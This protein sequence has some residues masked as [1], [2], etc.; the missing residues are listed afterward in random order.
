MRTSFYNIYIDNINTHELIN[1]LEQSLFTQEELQTIF[2][3]NAHCFNIAQR[4]PEYIA[5]LHKGTYSLNDGIGMKLASFL[6]RIKL[7]ENMN[8]TDLIPKILQ[9]CSKLPV[10]VYLLGG[11]PG[12]AAQARIKMSNRIPGLNIVGEHDGYFSK[13]ENDSV[14]RDIVSKRTDV[15]ILGMGVP[16]QEIWIINNKDSLKNVK[17]AIAGGAILDFEAGVVKRAPKWI[18]TLYLEWFF[19]F[20]QEPRRL[21]IRYFYGNILFFIN[22]IKT[23]NAE[24][25]KN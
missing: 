3:V 17:L 7:K 10:R 24:L 18:R 19:R 11:K 25:A 23:Y 6:K 13:S 8:G 16:H 21:F 5:A 22:L 12:V 4:N 14:V 9:F 1:N 20:L 15:L 2:F